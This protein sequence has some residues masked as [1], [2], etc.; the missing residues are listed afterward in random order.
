MIYFAPCEKHALWVGTYT[1]ID[2]RSYGVVLSGTN[3]SI[4]VHRGL[5]SLRPRN[6]LGGTTRCLSTAAGDR[7]LS[8][9]QRQRVVDHVNFN[10][11]VLA[12]ADGF[13]YRAYGR[14]VDAARLGRTL[15][16]L[17]RLDEFRSRDLI[18][19][20]DGHTL[21]PGLRNAVEEEK[22]PFVIRSPEELRIAPAGRG[23]TRVG[24][25]SSG[26]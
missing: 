24:R 6:A 5:L 25:R 10:I 4:R 19:Y 14:T 22:I 1:Q 16:G 11:E 15:A 2:A 8:D 17:R 9:P 7:I 3:G 12:A 18:V 23:P 13:T 20:M 26:P 21:P